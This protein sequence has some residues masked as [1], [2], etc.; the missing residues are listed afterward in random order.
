MKTKD[1]IKSIAKACGTTEHVI[2]WA[3]IDALEDAQEELDDNMRDI[4][5]VIDELQGALKAR[6][7]PWVHARETEDVI[8]CIKT[9]ID[10]L[11]IAQDVLETAQWRCSDDSSDYHALDDEEDDNEETTA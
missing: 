5:N 11:R 1:E 8:S 6:Y 9:A 3:Y 10:A 7:T 2:Y 4:Q